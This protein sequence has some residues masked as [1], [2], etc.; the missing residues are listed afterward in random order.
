MKTLLQKAIAFKTARTGIPAMPSLRFK[1]KE[2]QELAGA[3]LHGNVSTAQ[4]K[5]ALGTASSTGAM[6]CMASAY[7]RKLCS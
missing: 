2:L 4:A 6:S 5:H 7:R 3:W 1:E